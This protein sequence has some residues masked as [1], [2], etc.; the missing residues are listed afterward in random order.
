[1]QQV[2]LFEVQDLLASQSPVD[3]S[4]D[5]PTSADPYLEGVACISR[6][7]PHP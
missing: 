2:A 4:H 6:N 1:M 3:Q 7:H 5:F